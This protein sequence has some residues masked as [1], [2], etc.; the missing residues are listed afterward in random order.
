MSFRSKL[1]WARGA[2]VALAVLV[3]GAIVAPAS[4]YVVVTADNRVYD[5]PTKPEVRGDIVVFQLDGGLVSLRVYE[6]NITKTNELNYLLDSGA[7]ASSLTQQLRQLKPASPADDR[8]I[9]SSRVQQVFA[10]DGRPDYNIRL[11]GEPAGSPSFDGQPGAATGTASK[12]KYY[13]QSS[14]SD[15]PGRKSGFE[16]E[17]RATMDE[18]NRQVQGSRQAPSQQQA[19]AAQLSASENSA[20]RIAAI[21]ADIAAEQ[22]YLKKLT[23]GEETVS[24]LEGAID[25][26]MDKIRKLQKRRDKLAGGSSAAASPAA[27]SGP[28]YQS[29]GKYPAGSREAG[30]EEELT[31]LQGKLQRLQTQ[32]A[33]VPADETAE[34]EM[35]DEVIGETEFRIGKL[36]KKLSGN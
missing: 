17:A 25:S 7:G 35:L 14:F 36:E 28:A 27:P 32:R 29:S 1:S 31:S 2:Q 3:T 4:A 15:S 22:A 24:N 16:Q 12:A 26:S 9:V 10:E 30:W 6:V 5:V 8:M 20:D 33:S 19:S 18:A 21:D 11:E 34:R 23:A 13:G